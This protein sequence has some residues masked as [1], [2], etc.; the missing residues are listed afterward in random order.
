VV[1][2]V[3]QLAALVRGRLVGDGSVSIQSARPVGEAGPGDITFIENDR[4][5]RLLRTSPASAAIVGPHFSLGRNEVQ[6]S[7]A[8]IE[9]EDPMSAFLAVRTHLIGKHKSRWVGIHPQ[10]CVA[11]TAQVGH[12]V[13]IHAFAYVGEHATIGD[14]TTLH[15]GAVIGDG[16]TLGRD[17]I[18]HPNAVLYENVTLGDRVEIHGGSVL[19]GDGFG[20]RQVDGRHVKIPHSGRL[21]V[22]NDVEVGANSTID[23]A[24]F[25]TTR[26]GEGTKIDNLVM[27]GHNNQIGRHNLLCGQVGISGSCKTGDYVVIAGQAGIK[28]KTQ[29]GNRVIIGAQAGVHRNI[30][31]GQN[32]LG[33][34]AIP[35]R[36]QRRIF[37]M[38]ARLPEMHRQLRDLAAQIEAVSALVS[39]AAGL[40][41]AA[42]DDTNLEGP[43]AP[44]EEADARI[45][46]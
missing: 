46:E 28:D 32:V 36:E 8:V 39:P 4:F 41:V 26:I 30:S 44:A 20:Y 17:C 35:V 23:R 14:G 18:I 16:C 29:I 5:A 19:G 38:I 25:E 33:S 24:T 1:A 2:T 10:A 15:P 12:D 22:E 9:V 40:Q 43:A 27:I 37:Q 34:P 21:E 45:I 3:E 7:L 11:P 6:E 42:A 13:A 31:D